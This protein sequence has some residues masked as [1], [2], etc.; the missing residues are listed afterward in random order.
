M[1]KITLLTIFVF[2]LLIS[3]VF[4]FIF[5]LYEVFKDFPCKNFLLV[6]LILFAIIG[7]SLISV[8]VCSY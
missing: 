8:G 6:D 4:S 3:V 1:D 5:N 2:V 7:V